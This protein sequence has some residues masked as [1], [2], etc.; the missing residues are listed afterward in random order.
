M[1]FWISLEPCVVVLR[2]TAE[3]HDVQGDPAMAVFD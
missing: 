1:K 3:R 2:V